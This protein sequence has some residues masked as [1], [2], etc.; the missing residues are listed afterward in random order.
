MKDGKIIYYTLSGALSLL[1]I[2]YCALVFWAGE[3]EQQH[4]GENYL[5]GIP[6]YYFF[7]VAILPFISTGVLYL[8]FQHRY[9]RLLG[10]PSRELDDKPRNRLLQLRK[11]MIG[12]SIAFS[13]LVTISDAADKGYALPPYAF[14]LADENASEA[15]ADGY[16]CLKGW[17][18]CQVIE[19]VEPAVGYLAIL[20]EH[21]LSGSRITGFDAISDW[22]AESSGL[23]KF[24]SLLSFLAALIIS[25]FIT[26][27]FLLL[28]VKNYI[29]DATKQ[30]IIW[31]LIIATFWLPTKIYS[32]WYANLGDFATPSI[33]WFAVLM[34][35]LGGLV[36]FFIK[37]ERNQIYKYASAVAAISS[38][39]VAGVSWFK[40]ELFQKIFEIAIGLGW[41]YGL[42]FLSIFCL[43]LYLVTDYFIAN[44]EQEILQQ[45]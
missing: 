28:V 3:F 7:Y 18:E 31:L 22:Y 21:G 2:F 41:S 43:A 5:T 10:E 20:K 1:A 38:A 26:E 40:P 30:L 16:A 25:F 35:I 8:A 19:A 14:S 44:Y 34:V 27:V 9:I 37:T 32:A 13:V 39:A 45:Q 4:Y 17:I 42:M 11:L 29:L 6:N 15:I 23:Y 36:I 12:M 33:F 24:E